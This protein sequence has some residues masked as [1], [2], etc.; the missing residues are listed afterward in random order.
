[1]ASVELRVA[2]QALPGKPEAGLRWSFDL[3]GW[4]AGK[5]TGR[6]YSD[7]RFAGRISFE[8]VKGLMQ[9]DLGL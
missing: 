9:E 1:V 5:Y 4:K 2:G 6:L 3:R 8:V 7:G